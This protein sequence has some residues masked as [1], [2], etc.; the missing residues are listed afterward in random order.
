[1]QHEN[2]FT[3][4]ASCLVSWS[5][6]FLRRNTLQPEMSLATT[7]Q[8]SFVVLYIPFISKMAI[9]CLQVYLREVDTIRPY[10]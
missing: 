6:F 4:K 1:M 3:P 8:I 7:R 9:I 2:V 10:D 5:S